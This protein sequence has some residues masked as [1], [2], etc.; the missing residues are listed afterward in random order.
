MAIE[1]KI[2]SLYTDKTMSEALLPRTNTKA[3]TDDKGVNLNAILNQVAYVDTENS[4]AAVAPLNADTLAGFP[5]DNYASKTYVSN[6]IAKAQLGGGSGEGD[7][8]LSGFATKDDIA[9]FA[10][11]TLDSAKTYTND[12]ISNIDYPVDSVNGKTGNVQLSAGDIGARPDTWLP[13]IA[14][15]GAA[16]AGHGL[17][18]DCQTIDNWDNAVKAGF[19]KSNG[20]TPE[21]YWWWGYVVPHDET[22]VVQT[23]FRESDDEKLAIRIRK[24]SDGVWKP[25][26]DVSPSA[27]APTGFGLG[28][29]V[30]SLG[31]ESIDNITGTGF[32]YGYNGL[33]GDW[34]NSFIIHL[35]YGSY[36]RQIA[37]SLRSTTGYENYAAMREM[38]AGVWGDWA[39]ISP[40][41]FVPS[42]RTVNGKALSSNISLSAYDVGAAP[43]GYGLGGYSKRLEGGSLDD[44]RA[45]GWYGWEGENTAP[46]N[47]PFAWGYMVVNSAHYNESCVQIAYSIV[48]STK[49]MMRHYFAGTWS[50]W[51][52]ITTAE[53]TTILVENVHYGTSLPSA[54]TKGR[55]FFKVVS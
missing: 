31:N 9:T 25:W 13:T 48:D 12:K 45:N 44:I 37:Y 14:E 53:D 21:G 16:P 55:L 52:R 35:E 10:N 20:N 27:F 34:G 43:Y 41:A 2:T 46:T 50:E 26:V 19:Y 30:K 38:N 47:I 29:N 32:Y 42:S 40:S 54:G 5:A 8:D 51:K 1:G 3:I 17:G 6:E 49:T 15:I 18:G 28:T 11:T 36:K 24:S 23:I 39:D 22:N 33:P 7:I 4:E